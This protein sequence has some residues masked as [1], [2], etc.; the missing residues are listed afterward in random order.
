LRRDLAVVEGG[1]QLFVEDA[2]VRGVHVDQD[3][4]VGVLGEDV[5]AV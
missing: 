2:L 4:A 1:F 5:D 3:Q